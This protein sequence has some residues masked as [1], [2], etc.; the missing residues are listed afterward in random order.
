MCY[1]VGRQAFDRRLIVAL[2]KTFI[3]GAIVVIGDYLMKDLGLGIWRLVIDG[4][5][6]FAAVTLTG[7]LDVKGGIALARS[8]IAGRGAAPPAAGEAA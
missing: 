2:L 6:Y 3:I 4:V 1:L 7:A 8:A 5:F